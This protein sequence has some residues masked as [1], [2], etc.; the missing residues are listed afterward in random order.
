MAIDM[1]HIY[2]YIDPTATHNRGDKMNNA[3]HMQ[4][5]AETNYERAMQAARDQYTGYAEEDE[6]NAAWAASYVEYLADCKTGESNDW[7]GFIGEEDCVLMAIARNDPDPAEVGKKLSEILQI[8][9]ERG[10]ASSAD[11]ECLRRFGW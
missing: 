7:L 9:W 11:M 6:R 5:Q 1:P 10:A 3:N 4:R 8:I 2:G